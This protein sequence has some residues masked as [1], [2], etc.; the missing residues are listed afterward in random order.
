MENVLT[1]S[2]SIKGDI[3][4]FSRL[5]QKCINFLGDSIVAVLWKLNYV[6]LI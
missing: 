2:Q 4:K 1:A 3:R 6:L 5:L